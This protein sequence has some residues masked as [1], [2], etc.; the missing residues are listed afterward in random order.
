MKRELKLLVIS[1]GVAVMVVATAF[2]AFASE[3]ALTRRGTS[4]QAPDLSLAGAQSCTKMKASEVGWFGFTDDGDIDLDNQVE[5]YE[6]G[7]TTIAAVFE[8]TCVPKKAT[9][10]TIFKL[11]DEQVWSDKEALK[12]SNSSGLYPYSLGTNDNS[13]LPEGEWG[14]EFYN[15]KT[16]L[17][18]GTITVGGSGEETASTVTVQGTVKDKKSKKA[19]KGAVVIVLVPGVTIQKFIDGGQSDDDVL[20]GAKSDSKGNFVLEDQLEREVK[21]SLI[22][23]A[24]GYKPVGQDGFII[25]ADEAEPIELTVT[26]SK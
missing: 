6:S 21:Y 22:I 9:I 23:V 8:Y 5:S 3:P 7:T 20:T 2:S 14:V 10:V 15:N 26:M 19:I 25:A 11:G 17:T 4:A 13:E 24:K 1:V 12:A 16:L 18:K